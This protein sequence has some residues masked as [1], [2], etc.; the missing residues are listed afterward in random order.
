MTHKY[1][2]RNLGFYHRV[3]FGPVNERSENPPKTNHTD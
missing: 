1:L 2:W 3:N